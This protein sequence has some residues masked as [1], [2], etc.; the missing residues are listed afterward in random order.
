MTLCRRSLPRANDAK[1]CELVHNKWDNKKNP[2]FPRTDPR[3]SKDHFVVHHYAGNVVYCTDGWLQ[4]NMDTISMDITEL[5][6][7]KCENTLIMDLWKSGRF[8]TFTK[9]D[10]R[11]GNKVRTAFQGPSKSRCGTCLC[12]RSCF[13]TRITTCY[14]YRVEAGAYF[15]P[16]LPHV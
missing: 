5:C 11:T 16:G 15:V 7:E 10:T 9:I 3:I 12:F 4:K 8:G 14:P 2:G 6:R 1:F 13:R